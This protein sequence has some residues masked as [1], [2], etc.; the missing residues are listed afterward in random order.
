MTRCSLV[1]PLH[2]LASDADAPPDPATP[3]ALAAPMALEMLA[4]LAARVTREAL[5]AEIILAGGD[6]YADAFQLHAASRQPRAADDE[7]LV[8]CASLPPRAS[9]A[10]ACNAGAA[11]ATQPYLLFLAPRLLPRE[12]WVAPLLACL[13]ASPRAAAAGSLLL[14]TADTVHHAGIV[15]DQER[16]PR[17]LYAG[18]PASHPVVQRSRRLQMVGPASLLVRRELFDEVGGFDAAFAAED[19]GFDLCLRL[20]ERG[21]EIRICH[22]SVTS[23]PPSGP[24]GDESPARLARSTRLF[25][26]RWIH[27]LRPD[28]V[29]CYQED[30]LLRVRYG[31]ASDPRA[32][33]SASIAVAPPLTLTGSSSD[34]NDAGDDSSYPAERVLTAR[35]HQ[36]RAL[37][38]ENARLLEQVAG[39][40]AA[41]RTHASSVA[42]AP[43]SSSVA[44]A[45]VDAPEDQTEDELVPS[46]AL[47][48]SVGG[49]FRETG[50]EFF[51]Y[52]VD[53]GG[54]RPADAVL[55]VGCGVGRMAV[56]LTR[57]LTEGG[58]RYDGF[59][60]M[61]DAIAWCRTHITP[62]FPVFTF[63]HAALRNR[64]YNASATTLAT[65]FVFPYPDASFDF[66]FLTS[67]FTHLLP[68]E[69]QHYLS[70]I[71]RVLRPGGRCFSTFFLLN[72]ESLGLMRAG[73]SPHFP[74][75]HRLDDCRVQD[76]DVPE[77]AV[78]YDEERI[79]RWHQAAG[80]AIDEP[81]R[82]GT[83]CSRL[84][85]LSL[86]DIVLALKG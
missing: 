1:L 11:M 39:L 44:A 34:A 73:L 27:K 75:A 61:A 10:D 22:A 65:D 74:F 7:T 25:R 17:P 50:E 79:R 35:S 36:V 42:R 40:L 38:Q 52:F 30:R 26:T 20:G 12:G 43:R 14:T 37:L 85:G 82:Y 41:S 54:L 23:C 24:H 51:T 15:I 5:I 56:P 45:Q 21:F 53:I 69:V 64:A 13:A 80:L 31:D 28:D 77:A 67:V 3:T 46:P 2:D 18:F 66:V 33:L 16:R 59:D 83:W 19:A 29:S 32:P 76:A 49:D 55:E 48:L 72:A 6:A 70:E 71:V 78:A 8:R 47:A 58:G 62:R 9:F 57:F 81:V 63:Q 84:D 68:D 60:V 86:Q 4:S